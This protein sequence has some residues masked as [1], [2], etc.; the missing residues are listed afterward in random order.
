LFAGRRQDF[1]KKFDPATTTTTNDM[2]SPSSKCSS[3]S[4]TPPTGVA[5]TT[6]PGTTATTGA[7]LT[8]RLA[9][10]GK[11]ANLKSHQEN[12][13]NKHHT[14]ATTTNTTTL[15]TDDVALPSSETSWAGDYIAPRVVERLR[16]TLH[17]TEEQM[18]LVLDTSRRQAMQNHIKKNDDHGDSDFTRSEVDE[19]GW[20]P[21]QVL[22]RMVYF[23]LVALLM[24]IANRDYGNVVTVWFITWFPREANTLGIITTL[25]SSTVSS[26]S[27]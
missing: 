13:D 19:E 3:I 14:T 16:Q 21:H 24:Y 7:G 8:R 17:L 26:S 2:V 22:N 11:A 25:S 9:G 6:A 15:Q 12:D 20:T 5:T 18:K 4:I 27:S 1:K 10:R 23:I